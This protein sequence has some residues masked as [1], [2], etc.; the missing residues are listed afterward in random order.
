M[1]SLLKPFILTALT[2][3]I[4]AWIVPTVGFS[5]WS[6]LLI[7]SVVLTLLQR[8]VRP[9]LGVLFLPINIVT[10]GLF[11][12]VLNVCILWL[13]TF[14]VPGFSIEPMRIFSINLDHFF[15]LLVVS[16]LISFVQSF[17]RIFI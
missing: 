14:L 17:L 5:D 16:F 13:A 1:L 9:I 3:V 12:L 10:L 6:T 2:I 4:L 11:S 15:T 8:V 7:A